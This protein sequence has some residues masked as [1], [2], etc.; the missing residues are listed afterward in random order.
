MVHFIGIKGSGMA[1]LACILNDMGESVKGS[2]IEK[3][4]FTQKPL[5]ERNIQITSFD[6][7]NIS[8]NDTVIIGNAFDETN[9]EVKKAKSLNP[10]QV[11]YY[12][13]YLG[14]LVDQYTSISIAGTHGKTTTTSMMAHLLEAVKPTGYL[15]GDGRGDMVKDAHYFVLES[16]EYQRHFMAYHPDYAIITSVDL[17]HIDYYKDLDDYKKAFVDFASQVKKQVIVFGDDENIKT[18][19]FGDKVITYGLESHNDVQAVN[20]SEDS[21]GMKFDVMI[22]NKLW[23]HFELPY[24]GI[25]LCWNTLACIALAYL[26]GV[27]SDVVQRQMSSFEGAKRRFVVEEKGSQVYIDDYAHHPT[28]IRLTIEAARI[29]FP[30]K[31]LVAIFKPDRFSRIYVFMQDFADSLMSADDV[32]LCPFPDNAKK[33]EGID[34]DIYDLAKLIPDCKVMIENEENA[35]ILSEQEDVVY[36]FMS[37]KDIYKWKDIV[38][39]FHHA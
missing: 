4:I 2:D 37:S 32:I 20:F 11:Y 10:D 26:E 39:N 21:D 17:D 24:V 34:I 12:H 7:K 9:V 18:M 3:Y 29:K 19:N 8:E 30:N 13:E 15:I 31:K 35:K 25:H 23:G 38:K 33:E 28:A 6:E 16:C 36:L 22:H 14:K 5:E 27:T 1:S